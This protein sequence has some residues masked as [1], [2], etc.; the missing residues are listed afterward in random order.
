MY[1]TTQLLLSI[2]RGDSIFF[3][4]FDSNPLT[5]LAPSGNFDPEQINNL[6]KAEHFRLSKFPCSNRLSKFIT[7]N[8]FQ[9]ASL[10]CSG[11]N[12]TATCELLGIYPRR[13]PKQDNLMETY[14]NTLGLAVLWISSSKLGNG[15]RTARVV[16]DSG[17]CGIW[18][19]ALEHRLLIRN[20]RGGSSPDC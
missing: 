9:R 18:V 7:T 16:G 5:S 2:G 14:F 11:A 19:S 1:L 20:A 10:S 4:D 8:N 17:D 13:I 3:N 6:H 15:A 12:S